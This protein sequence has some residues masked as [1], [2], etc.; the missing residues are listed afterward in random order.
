MP[1]RFY[2][3]PT[4]PPPSAAATV[5]QSTTLVYLFSCPAIPALSALCS[6]FF[7]KPS[8]AYPLSNLAD[9]VLTQA[10][11]RQSTWQGVNYLANLAAIVHRGRA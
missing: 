6:G 9:P 7:L 8:G 4:P 5:L 3:L 1:D 10:V 2:R 11:S